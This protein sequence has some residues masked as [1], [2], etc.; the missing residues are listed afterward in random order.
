M[1][2]G[3]IFSDILVIPKAMGMNVVMEEKRGP[4]LP[5]PLLD[6]SH[7]DRLSLPSSEAL[8]DVFDTIYLFR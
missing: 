6:P 4:V 2:A 7:L 5:E 1:D 3:I 8:G